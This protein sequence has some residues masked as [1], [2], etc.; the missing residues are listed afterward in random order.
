MKRPSPTVTDTQ[1]GLSQLQAVI[2]QQLIHGESVGL[3]CVTRSRWFCNN[4]LHGLSR[5]PQKSAR[6]ICLLLLLK[7]VTVSEH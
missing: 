5:A 6:S 4:P 2:Q 7:E 3:G 1:R